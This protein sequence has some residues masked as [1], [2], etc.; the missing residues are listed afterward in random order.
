MH[1][2]SIV[3]ALLDQVEAQARTRGATAVRRL[4]VQIGELSGV[5]AA[6]LASAYALFRAGTLCE[7]AEMDVEAVPAR[8]ECRACGQGIPR[9]A[10]LRCPAC[11]T[12]ARLAGGDEVLL[13]SIEMEVP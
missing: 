9:G 7:A 11:G 8:W 12:P 4:R 13:R 1:E 3:Q 10:V 2:Y 5:E 6:L